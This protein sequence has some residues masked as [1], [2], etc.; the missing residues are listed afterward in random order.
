MSFFPPLKKSTL[1]DSQ[2]NE[3]ENVYSH[4]KIWSTYFG[5]FHCFHFQQPLPKILVLDEPL[6]CLLQDRLVL[7][8]LE[9]H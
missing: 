6:I 5:K 4:I 9:F 2:F 7:S 3:F 8:F 1:F